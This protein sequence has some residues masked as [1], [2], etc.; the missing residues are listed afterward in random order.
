MKIRKIFESMTDPD[1]MFEIFKDIV[2]DVLFTEFEK[3]IDYEFKKGQIE[4]NH[5][6]EIYVEPC[7]DYQEFC[8][9]DNWAFQ[10]RMPDKREDKLR[11]QQRIANLFERQTGQKIKSYEL[12]KDSYSSYV[13]VMFSKPEWIRWIVNLKDFE[14]YSN[15]LDCFLPEKYKDIEIATNFY[16]MKMTNRSFSFIFIVSSGMGLKM[17]LKRN[18]L[19][20]ELEIKDGQMEYDLFYYPCCFYGGT[21]MQ[22]TE[23]I[24]FVEIYSLKRNVNIDE[25]KKNQLIKAAQELNSTAKI[26]K[27]DLDEDQDENMD[28]FVKFLS[29]SV[30][31]KI[32][33]NVSELIEEIENQIFKLEKEDNIIIDFEETSRYVKEDMRFI[34]YLCETDYKGSHYI[35]KFT[36]DVS[37][38]QIIIYENL[39]KNHDGE[40]LYKCPVG[41]LADCIYLCLIDDKFQSQ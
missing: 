8:L 27:V 16:Y 2:D 1:D 13:T 21:W 20:N 39:D 12:G 33:S 37:K 22:L 26:F 28:E 19:L 18:T 23:K 24:N 34:S 14:E 36:L 7:D 10:F 30:F 3:E 32:Q 9:E 17:D 6:G 29:N 11:I 40:E 38:S 25:I 41:E 31:P 35:F 5:D 4:I 15:Q